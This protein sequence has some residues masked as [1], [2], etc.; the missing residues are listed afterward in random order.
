MRI[1]VIL[2]I[3]IVTSCSLFKA[4]EPV[5]VEEP[6]V[7]KVMIEEVKDS[8]KVDTNKFSII[9]LINAIDTNSVIVDTLK[10]E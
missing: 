2:G 3:S 1:L 10:S 5:I 9:D 6:I 7:E 8:V 4:E